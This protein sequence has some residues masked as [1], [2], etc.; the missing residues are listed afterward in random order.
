[1]VR[2]QDLSRDPAAD[3]IEG[4]GAGGEGQRARRGPGRPGCATAVGAANWE[5]VA[6]EVFAIHDSVAVEVHL[7]GKAVAVEVDQAQRRRRRRL[8]EAD[9]GADRL[10]LGVALG[11]AG[12]E[13]AL[14]LG[15]IG[16]AE[17]RRVL[18]PAAGRRRRSW[19]RP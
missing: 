4:L 13:V 7:V 5:V 19:W 11:D 17:G 15:R 6:A 1:M 2:V 14:V 16:R 8:F 10:L 3:R 12:I 9:L 18:D